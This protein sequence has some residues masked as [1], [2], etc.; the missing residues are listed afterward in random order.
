MGYE[1]GVGIIRGDGSGYGWGYG[2]GRGSSDGKGYAGE[3]D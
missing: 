3:E 1:K 2:S